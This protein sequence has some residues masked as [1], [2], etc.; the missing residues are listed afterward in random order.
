M[1]TVVLLS[2]KRCQAQLKADYFDI[3]RHHLDAGNDI[4]VVSAL[5]NI[6]VPYGVMHTGENGALKSMEGK[7][8]IASGI[9]KR[10]Q[11]QLN[12]YKPNNPHL[13]IPKTMLYCWEVVSLPCK[14]NMNPYISIEG[15]TD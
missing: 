15:V 4:T 8:S 11:A 14:G 9:D 6:Q 12:F 1:E 13:Q 5:K 10:C 3:Y 2:R 7:R